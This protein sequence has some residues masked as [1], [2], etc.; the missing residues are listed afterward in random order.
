[1]PVNP[2]GTLYVTPRGRVGPELPAH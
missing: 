1:M 2:A